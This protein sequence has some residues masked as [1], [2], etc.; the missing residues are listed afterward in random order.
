MWI[1]FVNYFTIFGLWSHTLIEG[2]SSNTNIL[3]ICTL[4]IL[5]IRFRNEVFRFDFEMTET[6]CGQHEYRSISLD[7]SFLIFMQ[8]GSHVSD[9]QV[10]QTVKIWTSTLGWNM[11][12]PLSLMFLIL[13]KGYIIKNLHLI[14][15]ISCL[16]LQSVGVNLLSWNVN[17]SITFHDSQ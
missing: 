16:N 3:I 10:S 17:V 13:R 14:G 5:W 2:M 15:T 12:H 7:W 8:S 4:I 1:V 6:S 9:S 11:N